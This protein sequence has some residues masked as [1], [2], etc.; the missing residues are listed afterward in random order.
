MAMNQPNIPP[1]M[2]GGI[3][4]PRRS[5]LQ[6]PV[7]KDIPLIADSGNVPPGTPVSMIASPDPTSIPPTFHCLKCWMTFN[8]KFIARHAPMLVPIP[9]QT[10][11]GLLRAN[12]EVDPAE[13]GLDG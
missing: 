4:I 9:D 11:D 1:S 10:A 7:C 13:E 12:G 6:C 2:Q 5:N 3:I 8:Y